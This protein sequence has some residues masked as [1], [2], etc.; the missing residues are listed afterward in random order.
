MSDRTYSPIC[1][2]LVKVI[3]EEGTHY[4]VLAGFEEK[5]KHGDDWR[6]SKDI[7]RVEGDKETYTFHC[8]S[9]SC[10]ICKKKE[11]NLSSQIHHVSRSL[12]DQKGHKCEIM[13]DNRDWLNY[14]WSYIK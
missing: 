8:S 4:R 14:E 2:V 7:I 1:W 12:L 5:L 6:I 11:Y 3:E 9:G 13:K 10:Y